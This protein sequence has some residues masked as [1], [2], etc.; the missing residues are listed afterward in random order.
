MAIKMTVNIQ[1]YELG[2]H[3]SSPHMERESMQTQHRYFA[4]MTY[5]NDVDEGGE[6]IFPYYDITIKPKKGTTLIWPSDWTHTHYG[7]VVKS[8]EKYIVTGWIEYHK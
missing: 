4:F 8:N 1:K 3:F 6:T 7:D 2:G 5:L